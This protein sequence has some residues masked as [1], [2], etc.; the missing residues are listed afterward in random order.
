MI[1]LAAAAFAFVIVRYALLVRR[2]QSP[3]SLI[4]LPVVAGAGLIAGLWLGVGS[5]AAMRVIAM[6]NGGGAFSAGGTL[7]VVL[8]FTA[9]GGGVGLLYA[10]FF[11][12]ALATSGL[13]FGALLTLA[14][15]YPLG[16]AAWQQLARK[17]DLVTMAAVSLAI[18]AAMWI[19]YA[20]ALQLLMRRFD[21][22]IHGRNADLNV[23]ARLR[24][25]T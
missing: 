4:E 20:L 7:Q 1:Y 19:P 13:L 3:A 5:R 9:F 15:W 11:R 21:R 14:T 25:G 22:T 6:A 10:G 17:P 12:H 23:T 8:V 24:P 18:I 2:Q 16:R